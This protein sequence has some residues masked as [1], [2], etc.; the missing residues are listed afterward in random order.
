MGIYFLGQA[1]G[2][3]NAVAHGG[4]RNPVGARVQLF[5]LQGLG[6]Q[7]GIGDEDIW[8]RIGLRPMVHVLEYRQV[9]GDAEVVLQFF[10]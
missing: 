2:V 6:Q 1:F 9:G 8:L 7:V 5:L 10:M 4:A 3:G